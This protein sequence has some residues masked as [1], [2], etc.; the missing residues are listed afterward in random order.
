MRYGSRY[1]D[2][3]VTRRNPPLGPLLTITAHHP[4]AKQVI[5][6]WAG[7]GLSTDACG[8]LQLY[9]TEAEPFRGDWTKWKWEL[10]PHGVHA[11]R[12]GLRA[13]L[14]DPKRF[15]STPFDQRR[16]RELLKGL[17]LAFTY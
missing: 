9:G 10:D 13:E 17:V 16:A 3:V 12:Q 2:F 14:A 4:A 15:E 8:A 6:G 11:L 7:G 5:I 1:Y